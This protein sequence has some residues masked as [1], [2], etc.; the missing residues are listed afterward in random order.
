MI[1]NTLRGGP[2]EITVLH[3]MSAAAVGELESVRS[4]L[5]RISLASTP[6]ASSPV[7]MSTG[8]SSPLSL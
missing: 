5:S 1:A 7:K 2:I 6:V 4:A 3:G 8:N